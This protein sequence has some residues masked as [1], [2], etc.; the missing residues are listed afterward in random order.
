[1]RAVARRVPAAWSATRH[2][3][4]IERFEFWC[5]ADL[6]DLDC[7]LEHLRCLKQMSERIRF[8]VVWIHRR[9]LLDDVDGFADSFDRWFVGHVG[10]AFPPQAEHP[11]RI[12][13]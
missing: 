3:D 1:M 13:V 10:I 6:D 2:L 12:E 4:I 8:E 7:R 11:W 9:E 5:G